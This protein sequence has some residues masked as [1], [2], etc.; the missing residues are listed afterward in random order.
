M[1]GIWMDVTVLGGQCDQDAIKKGSRPSRKW[2][3]IRKAA[4]DA[5]DKATRREGKRE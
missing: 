2:A 4:A 1:P 5:A 3:T